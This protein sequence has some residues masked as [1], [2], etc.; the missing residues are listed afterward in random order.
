MNCPKCD[1]SLPEGAAFCAYCGRRLTPAPRSRKRRTSGSG[2]ISKLSGK[3]SKPYLARLNGV[4]VG[5]F[6]TVR[7]AERALA[8]LVDVDITDKYNWSFAQVYEAWRPE[9]AAVLEVR[10]QAKGTGTTAMSSYATAYAGVPQLHSRPF[11][12]IRKG[13]LQAIL[14]AMRDEG[15][16][17]STVEK[18]RQL[19]GQLYRWA[20][21]EGIVPANLSD[22]LT[23]RPEEKTPPAVFTPEEIQAIAACD[24]PA[25]KI[26]LILLSTGVRIGELFSVPLAACHEDYF[27]GGSKTAAGVGRTVPVAPAGLAAY[28]SLLANA[29]SGGGT[30]L[31]DGYEGNRRPDNFR[32]RD[33]YAM[34]DALGISRAKTPHKTRHAYATA[35]V[36]SGVRPELLKEIIGHASYTTTIDLYTHQSR[37]DLLTESQ[38]ID[39]LQNPTAP[40]E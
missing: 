27:V 15:Y 10:A 23:I 24:L 9:H 34:L 1:R 30:R 13:E 37:Q 17:V 29:R 31:I 22:A 33:Y 5:T 6:A 20:I 28:Q 36:R 35:A 4:T 7:E 32:K 19:F 38:K 14:N 39:L 11:R 21:S 12:S 2:N 3:R 18:T 26:A 16:S 25:A 8:R 40:G